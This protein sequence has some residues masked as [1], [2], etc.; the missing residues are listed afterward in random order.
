MQQFSDCDCESKIWI[1]KVFFLKKPKNLK[2][3][4]LIILAFMQQKP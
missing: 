3:V 4:L 2:F 1:F